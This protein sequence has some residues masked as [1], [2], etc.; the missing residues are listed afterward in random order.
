[1]D[2]YLSL[3]WQLVNRIY[4]LLSQGQPPWQSSADKPLLEF[5]QQ[6]NA[7][8]R[9]LVSEDNLLEYSPGDGWEGLCEFLGVI[10]PQEEFPHINGKDDFVGDA[11]AQY[12]VLWGKLLGLLILV[13]MVSAVFIYGLIHI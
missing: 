9:G 13:C 2:K 6:H 8:I 10:K 3:H 1:M 4:F 12:W 11:R 5:Y 7:Y